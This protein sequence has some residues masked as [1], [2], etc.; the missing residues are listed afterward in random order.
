MGANA[1]RVRRVAA[2]AKLDMQP[3]LVQPTVQEQSIQMRAP[4]APVVNKSPKKVPTA[5]PY[6][7]RPAGAFYGTMV[8]LN[9]KC[10]GGISIPYLMGK[11]F[12]KYTYV[13]Y[14]DS[15]ASDIRFWDFELYGYD[16]GGD[17]V[18]IWYYTPDDVDTP[19]LTLYYA[20]EYDNVPVLRVN[21]AN[22]NYQLKNWKTGAT[23]KFMATTNAT[24][25]LGYDD[26][27]L[28]SKTML[29]RGRNGDQDGMFDYYTG[30][31]GVNGDAISGYWFGKN[32]SVKYPI[33]N[34]FAINGIAQAFEKPTRPYLLKQAVLYVDKLAAE[35]SVNMT[36]KIYR[37]NEIPAYD[38][39]NSVTLPEEPGELIATGSATVTPETAELTGNCIIFTLYDDYGNVCTPTIDD[40][41]LIA[42]D[43]YNDAGMENLS[44]FTAYISSDTYVDEGYGELAYVKYAQC[45]GQGNVGQYEWHG[46]NNFF[47]GS[48]SEMMTGLSI[49]ITVD[50]PYLQFNN[51]D[52]SGEY[53]FPASGGVMERDY[54][55]GDIIRSISFFT[56]EPSANCRWT[57]TCDGTDN[58]PNW[59]H[60]ELT[61]GGVGGVF[62]GEVIAR[63]TADPLPFGVDYREAVLRFAIPGDYIDFSF[64]QGEQRPLR[65]D[66]NGDGQ[67]TPADISVLIDYLLGGPYPAITLENDVNGD[68]QV[69]PADI[70]ALIDY[71]LSGEWPDASVG[72][73]ITVNGVSF[74]MVPVEGGTFMM[75]GTAEQGVSNAIVHEVTLSSYS[76]GQTE[77]TQALWQAV[78]GESISDIISRNEDF[79][80]CGIGDNY[81]MYYVSWEDCQTFIAELN[82]LTGRHFRLPTEAEFEYAARGGNLSRGFNYAGSDNIDEVAW[83]WRNVPTHNTEDA[84]YGAQPVATK[85]PNELGLYDMSGNVY[86][87]C[88]DWYGDYSGAPQVNPTSAET[89]TTRVLRGGSWNSSIQTCCVAHRSYNYPSYR[90]NYNGLRLAL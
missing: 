74:T 1:Q 76:I 44:N 39:Y 40:A 45:D 33:A 17:F 73:T 59:L 15:G 34:G 49:F 65:G 78:M 55:M 64:K 7:R 13:P 3:T 52:E 69:T 67:V 30:L 41:I 70:S 31:T 6:Y 10:L 8:L 28:S 24:E 85:A 2:P 87:W 4:G 90:A 42:I 11:P 61:D 51:F 71:L 86:D 60:V 56:S 63:V 26:L 35:G 62:D 50:N 57:V 25:M 68:G 54:G 5:A 66:L 18:P 37:L 29:M 47:T 38:D 43:G 82:R 81:P 75:G 14:Y 88:Q 23:G 84:G 72:E 19:E 77:V 53:T 27:M 80:L 89:G 12:T 58:I 16:E 48:R 36:C 20:V 83:H 9:G 21:T 22:N 79:I 46:L 32:G